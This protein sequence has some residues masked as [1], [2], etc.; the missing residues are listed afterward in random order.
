[1]RTPSMTVSGGFTD[2]APAARAAS[3][4]A[5]MSST[6]TV[7]VEPG[8]CPGGVCRIPPPPDSE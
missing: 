5:W 3:Y 1:M 8:V 4:A 7:G 2:S 6:C